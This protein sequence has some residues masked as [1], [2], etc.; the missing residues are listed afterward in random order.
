MNHPLVFRIHGL[1]LRF[2]ITADEPVK[3][4]VDAAGAP[5]PPP[6]AAPW[7][8][9]ARLVEQQAAGYNPD[10]HHGNKYT[11]TSPADLLRHVSHRKTRGAGKRGGARLEIVQA[12]G[13]LRVVSHFQFI[14]GQ[15]AFRTWTEVKNTGDASLL[16][17]YVSSLA[18]TGLSR[19]GGGRWADKM[20]LHLPDNNW[21]GECQWRSGRPGD[22]GLH[23]FY[24]TGHPGFGVSR[25]AVSS[26][27]TWSTAGA[28]PLGVLENT[29]SGRTHFWQI[30]HNGSWHWELS[31]IA[32]ELCLRASGPTWRESLWSER[33]APGATFTSVPVS[34]G[35]VAGGL[36]EALRSLTGVRRSIRRRHP[37]TEKLPVIFNDYMN[38]LQ[39]DPDEA[40]LLPL[41]A[42]AAEAGCEYFV[43]DAGWYAEAG[44]SWWNTVGEW[45][46]VTSRFPRGLGAVIDTIREHDMVPGLWLEIEV[47]GI[48]C[49]LARTLPDDWFFQRDGKRV[50]DHGRYQLDFRNPAVRAHADGVI[51]RLVADFRIGYLKMDY[52]INAGPGTD[53]AADSPGAGLLA[54]N[55]AY[56][57]WLEAVCER[58]PRLVI[59][60]CGSGGLRMDYAMLRVHPVQSVSDQTDYRLNA[61]IAAAAASAVAPEQAA[62]WSYSKPDG[63]EEE[64]IFNLVNA[65]LLRVH[66]SG[67]IRELTTLRFARI[68]EGLALYK[69]IR[70]DIRRGLPFWPLGLPK[71]GDG[72][73]AF[74]LDCPATRAR[75]AR[76]YLAVWRLDAREKTCAI[77]LSLPGADPATAATT[78]TTECIYPLAK[79]TRFALRKG[80]RIFSVTLPRRFTARLF[81]LGG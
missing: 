8:K 66:Q 69:K 45:Q 3:F 11:G 29:A 76:R 25:I 13:G 62:I 38:C 16:L 39:A 70:P 41:I 81:R 51:D 52:N 20:R 67:G 21:C 60:N 28:L 19:E 48:Q 31:D 17:E 73:L 27:G 24:A 10:D 40:K 74:G 6:L 1:V 49:P 30:E 78:A 42:K 34:Y 50:I 59:E 22:F 12:G 61:L 26:Q 47:M 56:L 68:V 63:D 35:I 32:G 77:P 54:H 4:T 55:R 7:L 36:Q 14:P 79:K 57:A 43:I 53:R 46:P 71:P 75:S 23:Q 44:R 65:L 72:W 9:R 64:T 2:Y 33:L 80:G 58:H 5:P 15:P 18:I 37:D